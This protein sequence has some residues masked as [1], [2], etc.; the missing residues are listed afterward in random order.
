[1]ENYYY[2][3]SVLLDL[4]E[5]VIDVT[6]LQDTPIRYLEMNCKN[7]SINNHL[8]AEKRL[9]MLADAK[10]MDVEIILSNNQLQAQ[11]NYAKSMGFDFF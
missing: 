11:H 8:L 4:G 6:E 7:N 2:D 1:M 3:S 10:N 9:V 5:R